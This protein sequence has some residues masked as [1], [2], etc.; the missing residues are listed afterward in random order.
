MKKCMCVCG[1]AKVYEKRGQVHSPVCACVCWIS[2]WIILKPTTTTT[3]TRN[4]KLATGE[5]GVGADE[6][7]GSREETGEGDTH[8]HIDERSRTSTTR[9]PDHDTCG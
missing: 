3:G 5:P 2:C 9:A 4:S 1:V 7:K 6:R 8:T